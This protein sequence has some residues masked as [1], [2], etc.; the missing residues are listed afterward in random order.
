METDYTPEDEPVPVGTIVDYFG[1]LGHGRYEITRRHTPIGHDA[2]SEGCYPDGYAYVIWRVGVLR[3]IGNGA[4]NSA[5][6]V[7]RTS[8]RII[9]EPK[10][11]TGP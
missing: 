8:F 3:K 11:V 5:H 2:G 7:R 1:S 6:N 10:G 4:G 9:E